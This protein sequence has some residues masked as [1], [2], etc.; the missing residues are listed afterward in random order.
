MQVR[1]TRT[2]SGST[3]DPS[4][5]RQRPA[6]APTSRKNGQDARAVRAAIRSKS[7]PHLEQ[8]AIRRGAEALRAEA[9]IRAATRPMKGLAAA[10]RLRTWEH[11]QGVF[12]ACETATLALWRQIAT[13]PLSNARSG[14][15]IAGSSHRHPSR[16]RISDGELAGI[17]CDSFAIVCGACAGVSRGHFTRLMTVR[18]GLP[19][20]GTLRPSWIRESHVR[21]IVPR[22]A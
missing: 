6:R 16:R 17:R 8:I 1:S 4:F 9:D 14:I 18:S 21:T 5:A 7:S 20:F 15:K 2:R 13:M 19:F 10:V 3:P 22:V 11:H 12:T